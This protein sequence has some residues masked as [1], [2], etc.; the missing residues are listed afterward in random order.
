MTIRTQR[1]DEG[2]HASG[3][4]GLQLHVRESGSRTGRRSCPSTAASQ[5]ASAGPGRYDSAL[6]ARLAWHLRCPPATGCTRPR[7]T[8]HCRA[9][10]RNFW[11]DDV[12][13]ITDQLRLDR[14]C[15]VGSV[16]R[17]FVVCDYVRAS[18]RTRSPRSTSS[19]ARSSWARPPRHAT[20]A[21]LPRPVR[22]SHHRQPTTNIAAMR[23]F[24]RRASSSR[25]PRRRPR[26]GDVLE[27][28]RYRH[29]PRPSRRA[30]VDGDDVLAAL[31]VP[32][33]VTRGRA[34]TV[35]LP[36]IASMSSPP[37]HRQALLVRRRRSRPAPRGARALQPRLAELTRRT[38]A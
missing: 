12:A 22:R 16:L 33:L 9:T 8:R 34:D 27:H 7:S 21:P 26:D 13:A 11:A 32:L 10:T 25:C 5:T 1:A 15:S 31:E 14:R 19:R 6:A 4:S 24:V 20:S 2:S 18:A 29:D 3:R 38:R 36:A 28:R 35:V 30:R 17:R 23:S 37:A